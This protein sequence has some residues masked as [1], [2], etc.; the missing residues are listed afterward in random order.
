MKTNQIYDYLERLNNL[1]RNDSR[2]K[3]AEHGLQPIQLEVLHYLSVC[4]RYSNTP[5]AVTEYLGQTKGTVSQTLKVLEKK[6]FLNKLSDDKDKRITHLVVT[7][8]GETLLQES[9]PT[10]LFANA[11]EGLTEKAQTQ[12]I[13]A[14]DQLLI[15]ML[16]ANS[17]KS[18]G[19]CRSCRYN[20]KQEEGSYFCD[21]LKQPLSSEDIQRICREH[22]DE[23]P[24]HTTCAV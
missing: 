14:L 20:Q 16:R 9:I 24:L 19:V 6:G 18:F 5:M 1:L 22:E 8:E 10:P 2:Q 4:N 11:C 21:L 15:A 13:T 7:T 23:N 3:G 12:I 17:M